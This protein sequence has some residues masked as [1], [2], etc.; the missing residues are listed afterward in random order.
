MFGDC[1][2]LGC[3]VQSFGVAG[4]PGRVGESS[5]NPAILLLCC[6]AALKMSVCLFGVEVFGDLGVQ[7]PAMFEDRRE[8]RCSTS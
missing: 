5:R 4:Q 3:M 6:R 7:P 8:E 1:V 2:A